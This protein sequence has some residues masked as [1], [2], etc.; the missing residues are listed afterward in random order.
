M[1]QPYDLTNITAADNF[2]ELGAATNLLTDGLMGIL[3]LISLWIILF[4]S[5]SKY[6]SK[7]AFAA[8]NFITTVFAIFFRVMGWIGDTPLFVLIL[9]TGLGFL[10]LKWSD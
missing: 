8:A 6:E 7:S 9:L 1:T 3:F 10:W 4:V 2:Y 5:F